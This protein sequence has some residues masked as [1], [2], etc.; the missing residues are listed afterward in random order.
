[1]T[2]ELRP[3]ET[4]GAANLRVN[5]DPG[6]GRFNGSVDLD[7]HGNRFTGEYRL[8]FNLSVNS[9]LQWGDRAS[10]RAFTTDEK[11]S[12]GRVAYDLPVGYYGTR[13]GVSYA[14]FDYA[15]AKEF[16]PLLANGEGDVKSLY[17]F[18]PFVRTRN[19]NLIL[20]LAAE[21]KTLIDRIDSTG[22]RDERNI[23]TYKAGLVGDFRD[24]AFGGGL[25]AYSFSYTW[26]NVGMSASTE[27]ADQAA[28]GR[29][30]LGNF[31]KLNYDLRR[32]QR[33]TDDASILFSVSGQLASRNLASAEKFSLG[34][35]N[36]VRA[37]PV[38]EAT[39]DSGFVTQTELRYIIP[40]FKF[41]NGD[42]T[43][44]AFYDYGEARINEEPAPT[45]NENIRGFGGYGIG[46]SLGREGDFL[47]RVSASWR[48]NNKE[49]PQADT[50]DRT[51]RFWLQ[52]I[53]WF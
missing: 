28:T 4:V 49:K 5:V 17:L 2:T 3:S 53:K 43:V 34:G 36:G 37:Y 11:M 52:A 30:T 46:G 38:G 39:A 40:G 18:H 9:P 24:G 45:D 44:L 33:L 6:A 31:H 27:V 10:V 42:A 48:A 15:L 19:S 47:L 16:A 20:A 35:P 12:Y 50:A 21:D 1:V 51:P 26:G 25:N 23:Y 29:H 7:N 41:L 22:S 8:G 14:H 13:V 32:Q